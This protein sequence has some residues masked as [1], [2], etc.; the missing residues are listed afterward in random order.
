MP[1][2]STPLLDDFNRAD[3]GPPASSNW[4]N[5][6]GSYGASGHKIVSNECR[7]NANPWNHSWWNAGV[8]APDSEV[9]ITVATLPFSNDERVEVGVR[10]QDVGTPFLDAY[11]FQWKQKTAG[12]DEWSL[13]RKDNGGQTQR[14]SFFSEAC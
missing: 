9:W 6:P 3:T 10:A 5:D 1:S 12:P 11:E 8:Y 7:G 14:A 2:P 4:S 13:F